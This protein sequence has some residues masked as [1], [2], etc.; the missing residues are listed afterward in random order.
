[1][2]AKKKPIEQKTAADVGLTVAVGTD[3]AKAKLTD[4]AT[5]PVRSKGQVVTAADA[6]DGAQKIVAFLK[7]RKFL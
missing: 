4:L 7:E 5:P 2:G 1:M 6:A 3:G